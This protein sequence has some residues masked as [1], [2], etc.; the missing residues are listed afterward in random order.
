MGKSFQ[1]QVPVR[2]LPLG[3]GREFGQEG[4]PP[5]GRGHGL[6]AAGLLPGREGLGGPRGL[7]Q[8]LGQA[9]GGG[10]LGRPQG[11]GAKQGQKRARYRI[12]DADS[13]WKSSLKMEGSTSRVSKVTPPGPR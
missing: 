7:L 10:P 9:D 6:L 8:H 13:L 12:H 11:D 5:M 1:L 4:G 3:P 2:M